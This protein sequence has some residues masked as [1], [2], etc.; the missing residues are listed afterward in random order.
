[1]TN[2]W[3]CPSK[4][5]QLT[6][7][8][9]NMAPASLTWGAAWTSSQMCPYSK[10]RWWLRKVRVCAYLILT[11]I[12]RCLSSFLGAKLCASASLTRITILPARTWLVPMSRAPTSRL[13]SRVESFKKWNTW[14]E[15]QL[16]YFRDPKVPRLRPLANMSKWT[17]MD[18]LAR[19][20][21]SAQSLHQISSSTDFSKTKISL[22]LASGS[23]ENLEREILQRLKPRTLKTLKKPWDL[24]M[25]LKPK[26]PLWSL[27]RW[28]SMIWLPTQ[29]QSTQ[30]AR[31]KGQC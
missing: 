22:S 19:R 31:W 8:R 2:N 21:C 27:K 23:K 7:D 25:L 9:I 11:A 20:I 26:K 4:V 12:K 29:S 18:G 30:T 15:W 6:R 17:R 28:K 10:N 16:D 24:R 14:R 3:G 5:A 1:M 13:R